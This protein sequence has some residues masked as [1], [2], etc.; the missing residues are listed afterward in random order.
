MI[1]YYNLYDLL[2]WKTFWSF[3]NSC[4]VKTQNVKRVAETWSRHSS[5][6]IS[7]K[8]FCRWWSVKVA[9]VSPDGLRKHA[10][11]TPELKCWQYTPALLPFW[12]RRYSSPSKIQQRE[13]VMVTNTQN[14]RLHC[15][16]KRPTKGQ[17]WLDNQDLCWHHFWYHLPLNHKCSYSCILLHQKVSGLIFQAPRGLG[18]R[19]G[20]GRT[21]QCLY[22]QEVNRD[23]SRT[24]IS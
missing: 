18:V 13:R 15:S 24:D 4:I 3:V 21:Y 20:L 12:V 11:T 22:K 23:T 9:A 16:R 1:S 5:S 7:S 8:I 17:R 2:F 10:C 19:W 6:V 14:T